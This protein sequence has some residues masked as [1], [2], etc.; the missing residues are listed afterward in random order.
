MKE[1][2]GR[3]TLEI[4]TE[5]F[6]IAII[7]IFPMCVDSTGFFRILE[8]KYRCFLVI[9]AIY[10][11]SLIIAFLYYL[12]FQKTNLLR[13]IKFNKIHWILIS[14]LGVN[15]I[16]TFISPF[17]SKYNLFVG[18][19]RAEG[20]ISIT[21]YSL[22]FL[23]ITLFGKFK[24]RYILYFSI[25]SILINII[26]IL[27][28]IGFNPFNMYQDGI[29]THNVS[30]IGTI[31]NVD[32][33]SA[34]YCIVLTVSMSAYIFL[35][36]NKKIEKIIYLLATYMGFFIFEVLDV[37]SGTVAFALTLL[38][39]SPFIITNSKRL[40]RLLMIG[41]MIILGYFTNLTINPTFY[42][43]I[44]R[45]RLELQVNIISTM[46]MILAV[47][48]VLLAFLISKRKFDLSKNKKVIKG[49]Y[50]LIAISAI[51]FIIAIYFLNFSNGFLY[52]IHEIL[53]GNLQDKFGTYRMFL[54]KRS[55]EL[56]KDY[57]II[58]TGPDTF[59]VRFMS[60]YAKEVA[61]LGELTINDTAA[62]SYLTILVNTGIL[63]FITYITF[64]IFQLINVL[65]KT[66]QYSIIFL[67]TFLCF[68][69]QDFF[70]LWVVIVTPLFWVLMAV[71]FLTTTNN[72][73]EEME[74]K[75]E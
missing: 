61:S 49:L 14:F 20:L 31:G 48:F 67:I 72:K 17:F 9:N 56:V 42:Y 74:E 51:A 5:G 57:P 66:N 15:V 41:A 6:I 32:F 62:N 53:H 39:V 63:G 44:G 13:D 45:I 12:L 19:G 73:T 59:A 10:I 2:Q 54:W 11:S 7:M 33:V 8:C 37:L 22:S 21:L 75:N 47:I 1:E 16:S 71:M 24:R 36:D 26:S 4:I 50:L 68:I 64:L 3:K 28:Y 43:D 52:E 46:L 70:N 65:K 35:E 38:I 58:G 18:V 69:I 60:K 25:S 55:I 29:G 40:A 27:Q 30:F 34:V 23:N